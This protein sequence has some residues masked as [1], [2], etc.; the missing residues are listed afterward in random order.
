MSGIPA[1]MSLLAAATFPTS[2]MLGASRMPSCAPNTGAGALPMDVPSGPS[3]R[4][5]NTMYPT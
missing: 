4:L 2:E 1:L 3:I 5:P